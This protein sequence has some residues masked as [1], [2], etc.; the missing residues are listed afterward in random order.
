MSYVAGSPTEAVTNFF[1]TYAHRRN[2]DDTLTYLTD[3]IDWLGIFYNEPIRGI[4]AVKDI[5]LNNLKT[6]PIPFTIN[7]KDIDEKIINS[8]VSIVTIHAEFL[9]QTT[10]NT[11]LDIF[12]TLC[13]CRMEDAYKIS[14]CHISTPVDLRTI[15]SLLSPYLWETQKSKISEET[16]NI[17]MEQT[18]ITFWTYDILNHCIY[19]NENAHGHF[20]PNTVIYNV[21]TSLKSSGIIHPDDETLLFDMFSALSL[22]QKTASC[23]V[24]WKSPQ[25]QDYWWNR[26]TCTTLFDDAGNAIEVLGSFLDITEKIEAENKFADTISYHHKVMGE[27]TL[28]TGHCSITENIIL[29][30]TN[31]TPFTFLETLGTHRELFF[32]KIS[33]F[34]LNDSEREQYLNLFL[35][36]PLI[37]NFEKGITNHR[38]TCQVKFPGDIIRWV[39]Q[40]VDVVKS[41]DSNK[42]FGFLSVTDITA[43]KE[44]ELKLLEINKVIDKVVSLDYDMLI[45]MDIKADS[46][47]MLGTQVNKKVSQPNEG[48]YSIQTHNYI[49]ESVLEEDQDYCSREFS[50]ANLVRN[51]ES[52]GIYTFHYHAKDK[53]GELQHKKAQLFYFDEQRKKVCIALSDITDVISEQEK[54][55]TLLHSALIAAEQASAAKSEFFSH[56]S[57]EIRTPMNAI[58]GMCNIALQSIGDDTEIEDCLKKIE[59]SSRF[60]LSLIND[61]LD[62]SRIESGKMYLKFETL[63]FTDFMKE[64]NSI[65]YAQANEKNVHY[66]QIIQQDMNPVYIGDRLKL[67]QV[68]INILSNAIKFTPINGNITLTVQQI[69]QIKENALVRFI[70]EDTGC[71]MDADFLPLLFEPFLQEQDKTGNM[72]AGTGLGLAICKSLVEMMEGKI[73]VQSTKGIGSIFTV[74]VKLGITEESNILSPVAAET[75]EVSEEFEKNLDFTGK[76][77][78]LA[79][80]HPINVEVATKILKK[81]GFLVEVATNGLWAV[82]MFS[83]TPPGYYDAILMDIRM[84]EMDGLQA[85]RTI[86]QTIKEDAKYIPI[87]AMTANAFEEDIEKSRLAGM[88]A[89][90][91]KPINPPKLFQ[92]LSNFL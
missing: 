52:K 90:L 69:Q 55:N 78:L 65:C 21:P 24:R 88:N 68:I 44:G 67:Q 92:T 22:G 49:S 75:P 31:N 60:L 38:L 63:N 39:V 54:K 81:K 74:D 62:M 4:D 51:L 82:K 70:I 72:H 58:V 3:D 27:K 8:D 59:S 16:I 66:Q 32:T 77:I 47:V 10:P 61:I 40:N 46:Y 20:G 26:I 30:V 12:S 5:L 64:I 25:M 79:E 9:S 87:I 2:L 84:P 48:C 35:R 73:S 45:L 19:Q 91:A 89:H 14:S 85:A 80:D 43:E 71:G 57:H 28:F 34:I 50:S 83:N 7:Y 76:K 41:P 17:A 11:S 56:M 86:R 33:E 37:D 6:N 1:N 42:L 36:Q 53:F 29:R 23:I 15:N 18:G 13:C